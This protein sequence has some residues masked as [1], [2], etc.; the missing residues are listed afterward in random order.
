MYRARVRRL[1]LVMNGWACC[2]LICHQKKRTFGGWR[3]SSRD[4]AYYDSRF[5]F[6]EEAVTPV[7]THDGGC[8]Q[9]AE[10][11]HSNFKG[12]IDV[13]S[14]FPSSIRLSEELLSLLAISRGG[15]TRFCKKYRT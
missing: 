15:I 9:A 6:I 1:V 2:V 12:G 13:S 7:C 3:T 8:P 4:F 10:P 5:T 11:K 14:A